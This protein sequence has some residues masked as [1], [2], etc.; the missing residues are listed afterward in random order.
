MSWFYEEQR[1]QV[2]LL[3]WPSTGLEWS[4]KYMRPS[5][6]ITFHKIKEAFLSIE[7]TPGQ[8]AKSAVYIIKTD[9][10]DFIFYFSSIPE[11]F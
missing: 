8:W 3:L 6:C 7:H 2:F 11:V 10:L 5:L 9:D 4:P 1:K